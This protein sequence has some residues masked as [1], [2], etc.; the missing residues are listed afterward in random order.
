[1]SFRSNGAT[2]GIP[3]LRVVT[4]RNFGPSIFIGFDRDRIKNRLAL[5]IPAAVCVGCVRE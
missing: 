4:S 2:W 5:K 3:V 1:M